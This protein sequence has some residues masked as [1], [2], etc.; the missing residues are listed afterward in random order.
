MEYEVL[1]RVR[2]LKN[3]DIMVDSTEGETMST[4]HH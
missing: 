3:G 2:T 4:I 1:K